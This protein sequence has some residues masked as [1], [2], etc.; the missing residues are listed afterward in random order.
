MSCAN[1]AWLGKSRLASGSSSSR[2]RGPASSSASQHTCWRWPWLRLVT[3]RSAQ[4]CRPACVQKLPGLGLGGFA[5]SPGAAGPKPALP[6]RWENDLVIRV[7]KH[8]A[9]PARA[10]A[11]GGVQVLPLAEHL[12][13]VGRL[14]TTQQA[15]QAGFAGTVVANQAN[16]WFVQLQAQALKDLGA[17]TLQVD[18]LQLQRGAEGKEAVG[19]FIQKT[20]KAAQS[21]WHCA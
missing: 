10:L 2:L 12:A 15:Q 13:L 11:A 16:A 9:H 3:A 21:S 14:Q 4:S 1:W 20:G 5:S 7:L 6:P 17:A 18:M 19:A 8:H